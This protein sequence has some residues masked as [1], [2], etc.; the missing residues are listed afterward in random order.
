MNSIHDM[1]GMHGFGPVEPER[2]EPVFHAE[3]EGRVMAMQRSLGIAGLWTI[4]QS[5]AAQEALPPQKYIGSSYY[6]RWLLGLES[7]VQQFNLV[8]PDELEAGKSLRTG[9][10]LKRKFTPADA[11]KMQRGNFTRP[12]SEPPLFEPGQRVRTINNHPV[13]HTRLPRYARDKVGVIEAV[14]GFCVY[15]DTIAIG[16]GE[17]PQWLYTVVIS[18][19]ELWGE[20][21]D[22]TISVSIEAFEPYLWAE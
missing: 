17:N 3:W 13:T 11:D 10:E 20:E 22:P 15:P 21:S 2:D 18:G 5:R 16:K 12:S 9:P 7:R 4:D 19:P 8:S 1:G 6:A 14:R